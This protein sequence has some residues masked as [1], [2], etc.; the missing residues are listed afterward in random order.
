M[1]QVVNIVNPRDAREPRDSRNTRAFERIEGLTEGQ[2]RR[3]IGRVPSEFIS[4][5]AKAF[6]VQVVST[7]RQALLR[8]AR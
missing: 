6:A 4:D 2:I 7:S 5:V 8:S 3:A 1:S